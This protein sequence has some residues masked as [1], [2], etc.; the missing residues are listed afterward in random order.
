MKTLSKVAFVVVGCAVLIAAVALTSPRAAHAVT[1]AYV[2]VANTPAQ[3]VPIQDVNNP[4][5]TPFGAQNTVVIQ[6]GQPAVFS[7]FSIPAGTRLVVETVSA[8][9]AGGYTAGEDL[10]IYVG[11]HDSTEMVDVALPVVPT[12]GSL[13]GAT[14]NVK[15]YVNPGNLLYFGVHRNG[16]SGVEAVVVSVSGYT[17][18]AS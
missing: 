16:T 11:V 3:P 10:N 15:M 4:A 1:A 12:T 8:Y 7:Q 17:V 13:P 2:L 6:D 5:Q 18:P 9:R 14:Q